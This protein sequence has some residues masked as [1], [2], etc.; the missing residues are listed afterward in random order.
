MVQKIKLLYGV[1]GYYIHSV[2]T[3]CCYYLCLSQFY[4]TGSIKIYMIVQYL[5]GSNNNINNNNINKTTKYLTNWHFGKKLRYTVK[6]F[7]FT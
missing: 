1:H 2:V 7:I 3:C 4:E 5:R 6:P